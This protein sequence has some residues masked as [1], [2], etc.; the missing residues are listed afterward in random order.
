MPEPLFSK[1]APVSETAASF[2]RCKSQPHSEPT[3][4]TGCT[5]FTEYFANPKKTPRE[6]SS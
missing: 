2:D 1:Q 6:T 4:T 3:E 5:S